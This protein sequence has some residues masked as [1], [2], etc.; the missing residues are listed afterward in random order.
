MNQKLVKGIGGN[1]QEKWQSF[2]PEKW[3]AEKCQDL[4]L[5]NIDIGSLERRMGVRT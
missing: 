5:F 3:L 1:K 4:V 2:V